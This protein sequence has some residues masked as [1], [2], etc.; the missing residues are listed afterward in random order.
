MRWGSGARF[1]TRKAG[2]AAQMT[3]RA[4]ARDHVAW[5]R[6]IAIAS[7]EALVDSTHA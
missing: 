6:M 7:R 3:T 2:I 4:A 1:R 5:R